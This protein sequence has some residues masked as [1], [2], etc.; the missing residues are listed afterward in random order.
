MKLNAD[1][2][3][4]TLA[5]NTELDAAGVEELIRAL[6][7]LRAQMTPGVPAYPADNTPSISHDSPALLM[8]NPAADGSVVLRLGSAG[9]GWTSWRLPAGDIESVRA[10]LE[11]FNRQPAAIQTRGNKH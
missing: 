8:H 11:S 5:I 3:K 1:A 9:L 10:L 7:M 6:A 2:T 4:A